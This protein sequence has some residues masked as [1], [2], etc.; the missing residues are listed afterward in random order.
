MCGNFVVAY[1]MS[2]CA[3]VDVMASCPTTRVRL[4]R[5]G[6]G[7][8]ATERYWIRLPRRSRDIVYLPQSRLE[9]RMEAARAL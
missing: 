7:M 9:P 6:V 3:A 1:E 8:V 4:K 5:F 2:E